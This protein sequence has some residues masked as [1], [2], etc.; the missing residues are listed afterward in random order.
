MSLGS[1]IKLKWAH[2]TSKRRKMNSK[3]NITIA[4][5]FAG[6]SFLVHT[7]V[8]TFEVQGPLLR[9]DVPLNIQVIF[10][11]CWHI[12]TITLLASTFIFYRL[13]SVEVTPAVGI[14]LQALGLTW[15]G[16]GLLFPITAFVLGGMPMVLQMPQ[17]FVL[18]PAGVFAFLGSNNHGN[19]TK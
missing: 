16:F 11:V 5:G 4:A 18:L 10:M 1:R 13:R 12:V 6:I 15:I 7:F 2:A 3:R 14:V 8:G 9:S 17:V 19:E